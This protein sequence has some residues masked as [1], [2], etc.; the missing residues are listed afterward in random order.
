MG[1]SYAGVYLSKFTAEEIDSLLEKV[2]VMQAQDAD[3]R[4][5][6]KPRICDCCGAPLLGAVCEYCGV[7]YQVSHNAGRM[8]NGTMVWE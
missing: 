7:G 8:L 4:P 6:N 1:I 3:I 2:A 5:L